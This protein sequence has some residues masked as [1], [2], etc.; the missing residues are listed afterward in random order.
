MLASVQ[1]SVS[2]GRGHHHHT[3]AS[4]AR[5]HQCHTLACGQFSHGAATEVQTVR[6]INWLTPH[7]LFLCHW[8][9]LFTN[10]K[11][12]LC[13]ALKSSEIHT[14][15]L[16]N[17]NSIPSTIGFPHCATSPPTS[18]HWL[19][20]LPPKLKEPGNPK[21]HNMGSFNHILL[22]YQLCGSQ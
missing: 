1:S 9:T 4:A 14:T 16:L 2:P 15:L 7:T 3:Q 12:S 11:S 21:Q 17:V 8:L 13:T 18:R 10:H 19:T 22:A 6:L 5:Y 20:P